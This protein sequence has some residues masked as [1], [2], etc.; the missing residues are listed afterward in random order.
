[1]NG[2]TVRYRVEGA[3]FDEVL[4]AD[5]T[6]CISQNTRVMNKMIKAIEDIGGRSGMKLNKAKCEVLLYGTSAK[7][8]FQDRTA[9]QEVSKAKYLGCILNKKNDPTI[10]VRG[11]IR[12]AMGILKKMHIFWRHSNCNIRFKLNVVQAVMYSKILFA[13]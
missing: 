9:I 1:M 2:G 11:R 5:D 10:E 12:E 6:I 4:F 7:I 13:L 3:R 8:T